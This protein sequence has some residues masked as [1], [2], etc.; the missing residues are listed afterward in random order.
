MNNTTDTLPRIIHNGL[1]PLFLTEGLYF[2]TTHFRNG[3]S[4]QFGVYM[5]HGSPGGAFWRSCPPLKTFNTRQEAN[6]FIDTLCNR[7]D[8]HKAFEDEYFDNN[9]R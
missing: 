8:A 2:C 1:S 7:V 9:L 4:T 3:F 5:R 6:E